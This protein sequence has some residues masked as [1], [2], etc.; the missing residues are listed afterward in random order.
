MSAVTVGVL[1]KCGKRE[2]I[3]ALSLDRCPVT[4]L[5]WVSAALVDTGD[6][7]LSRRRRTQQRGFGVLDEDGTVNL[8]GYSRCQHVLLSR[9]QHPVVGPCTVV[10][11]L[12]NPAGNVAIR[13]CTGKPCCLSPDCTAFWFSLNSTA[14]GSL[15]VQVAPEAEERK[16]WR[17]PIR[18]AD[19]LHWTQAQMVVWMGF[20]FTMNA[21]VVNAATPPWRTPPLLQT[22]F[23]NAAVI[24]AV[25]FSKVFL[26]DNKKYSSRQ[27]VF[28]G[29]LIV[30]AIAVSLLPTIMDGSAATGFNGVHTLA[31]CAIYLMSNIPWAAESVVE[32][33]YLIRC[34]LLEDGATNK[35]TT[36]GILRMLT[37]A[38]ISQLFFTIAFFWVD[39]LPFF[40]MSSSLEEFWANTSQS[41][42]CSFRGP[43]G[44]AA[45]GGDP[46]I[47]SSAAPYWA[48]AASAGYFVSYIADAVLNR[49]SAAF[50]MLNWVLITC[51][52][53]C[54]FL[55]PGMNPNPTDT[56]LWSVITSIV[57]SVAGEIIWKRWEDETE[58]KDQFSVR[59][60][61]AGVIEE[62]IKR[63]VDVEYG[64]E[65]YHWTRLDNHTDDRASATQRTALLS[66]DLSLPLV[67]FN[68]TAGNATL[69]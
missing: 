20:L 54:F 11:R 51:A 7:R 8:W 35:D 2:C 58:A 3:V 37:F 12:D 32:Q 39:F 65:P 15:L 34:G 59:I 27:P 29:G 17:R 5:H 60:V 21:L 61:D 31:W 50:S 47:C 30:T 4:S 63:V 13:L 16:L 67:T 22:I 38:G 68:V 36:I 9:F 25:P 6:V 42:V 18:E 28:A 55:I 46:S 14:S 26:G 52:T 45:M 33:A 66:R 43:N 48:L 44:V 19:G 40:G 49:E 23:L 41:I 24:F 64:D 1:C 69:Q 57:L 62:K 10:S 56:P 53:T